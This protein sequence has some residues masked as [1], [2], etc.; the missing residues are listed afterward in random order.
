MI[1]DD[2]IQYKVN[3]WLIWVLT[4]ALAL[5]L[6][7][8][9]GEITG[10]SY[11]ASHGLLTGQIIGSLICEAFIWAARVGILSRFHMERMFKQ[12]DA[13]L[14]PINEIAWLAMDLAVTASQKVQHVPDS[15]T[16]FGATGAVLLSAS[17]GT[18]LWLVFS[19]MRI[20]R[21]QTRFRFLKMFLLALA[22]FVLG[23]FAAVLLL[24]LGLAVG[25]D[26]L[27]RFGFQWGLIAAGLACGGLIGAMT[28]FVWVDWLQPQAAQTP[29]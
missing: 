17:T 10:R 11:I 1:S 24:G 5:A 2:R 4:N 26:I 22:G 16:V 12:L 20:P 25:E 27:V 6:G 15:R 23:T 21:K 3:F 8:T 29:V 7:L 28:G 14:W 9:I 19:L 18:V 13:F